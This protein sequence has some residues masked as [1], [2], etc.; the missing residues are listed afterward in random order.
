MAVYGDKVYVASDLDIA[1]MDL[2]LTNLDAVWWSTGMATAL[3]SGDCHPLLIFDKK[4]FVG[5]GPNLRYF[6]GTNFVAVLDLGEDRITALDINPATGDMFIATT[7]NVN[8]D[9][10]IKRINKIKIWDGFSAVINRDITV[11]D[12][13]TSFYNMGGITY[14]FYGTNMGIWNGQGITFLRTLNIGYDEAELIYKGRATD[15][16][17][18][19]Y[20]LEAQKNDIKIL[21]Y[22][23]VFADGKKVFH[24]PFSD[25]APES[26]SCLVNMGALTP[27]GEQ[28]RP[29]FALPYV[30]GATNYFQVFNPY[31]DDFNPTD[32]QW[33][34]NVYNLPTNALVYRVDIWTETLV[35]GDQLSVQ[36]IND[37]N[38]SETLAGNISFLTDGAIEKKSFSAIDTV[39][40][41]FQI[42]ITW[43]AG[44]TGIR[45]VRV[46]YDLIEEEL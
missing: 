17:G 31:D 34:S 2:D 3:A 21:A 6:D 26:A 12:M 33:L 18:T 11:D 13:V 41:S 22:G 15:L 40:S 1:Q 5:D 45:Q 43:S 27:S 16:N 28:A 9:G 14:I 25:T 20:I 36:L 8:R 24:Y 19:L 10:S 7:S 39:T 38:V 30:D 32:K 29:Y 46:F 35:S 42:G 44:Y 37:Q 4:L 23:S